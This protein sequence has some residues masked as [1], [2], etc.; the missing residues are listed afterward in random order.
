MGG[1]EAQSHVSKFCDSGVDTSKFLF[2]PEDPSVAGPPKKDKTAERHRLETLNT[3]LK[4]SDTED[5]VVM[6]M[7]KL[8]RSLMRVPV[9]GISILDEDRCWFRTPDGVQVFP[10]NLS[11]CGYQLIPKNPS[12]LVL[13]NMATNPLSKDLPYVTHDPQLRFYASAPLVASN[14][15]RLG[16][17]CVVDLQPRT[18][19][20][21]QFAMLANF[22]ECMVRQLEK[23]NILV[24]QKKAKKGLQRSLDVVRSP[25][26]IIDVTDSE[27]I[28]RHANESLEAIS[29]VK[30][31]DMADMRFWDVF[32]PVGMT[33]EEAKKKLQESVNK[34][35]A[36]S[37]VVKSSHKGDKADPFTFNLRP[38]HT[39]IIDEYAVPIVKPRDAKATR[40]QSAEL[41]TQMTYFG[42][43][44]EA[45][46]DSMPGGAGPVSGKPAKGTSDTA[47]GT[48]NGHASAAAADPK[49]A[50]GSTPPAN[51]HATAPAPKSKADPIKQPPKDAA[52]QCC[53]V[54]VI[55]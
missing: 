28:I 37:V 32:T 4:I 41:P 34:E 20:Q 11:L 30:R 52:Q 22:A 50:N 1:S 6:S 29:G 14:G 38:Y 49:D 39:N 36:F 44:A 23:D 17:M 8:L 45:V 48:A 12:I 31:D 35:S 54:C 43:V 7:C 27:W 21:E 5:P 26:V 25:I 53:G 15:D 16:T 9:A 47:N 18:L 51:G 46:K 2:L 3:L 10:H 24:L 33:K 19:T 40:D 55:S 42:T 13:E